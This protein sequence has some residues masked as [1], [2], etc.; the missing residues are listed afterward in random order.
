MVPFYLTIYLAPI[1]NILIKSKLYNALMAIGFSILIIGIFLRILSL[2]KLKENFSLLVES[3]DKNSLIVNGLYKH[4]R[5]PLYM[6]TLLIAISGCI[7]FTCIIT[8]I[9][10]VLTTIGILRRIKIEE[11][12]LISKFQ[13]YR[14]YMKHTKKLIPFLY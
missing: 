5:H 8:W 3:G 10:F 2:L 14:D 13:E 7:I 6:A 1:E 9:F 12:F 11:S 4:I